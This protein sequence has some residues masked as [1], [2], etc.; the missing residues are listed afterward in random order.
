MNLFFI[1]NTKINIDPIMVLLALIWI[2]SGNGITFLTVCMAVT[3]HEAAHIICAKI[4]GLE[5]ERITLYLFGGEAQ[6]KG[7]EH[8]N[9]KEMIIASAG[10]LISLL[11]GFLW[12]VGAQQGYLYHLDEFVRYSYSIA[13][14]NLLPVYPLDGGRIFMSASKEF[15]G[16]K[17]GRAVALFV[18]VTISL[19]YFSKCIC[20]MAVSGKSSGIVM[21][22]FMLIAS[23]KAIKKPQGIE[24]REGKWNKTESIKFIKAYGNESLLSTAKK[25]Y[26]NCFFIVIVFNVENQLIGVITEKQITDCLLINNTMTLFDALIALQGNEAILSAP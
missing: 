15:L 12:H 22:V 26:G 3:V 16:K 17:R 9:A 14:I 18:G 13:L 10:P 24:L 6:I 7:L 23:F 20:E 25:F 19:I 5:T 11:T 1:R 8:D 4:L 21:S 2:F